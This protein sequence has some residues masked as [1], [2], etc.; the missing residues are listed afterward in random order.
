MPMKSTFVSK[1]GVSRISKK[2]DNNFIDASRTSFGGGL[3]LSSDFLALWKNGWS[4]R[5]R[6]NE[7]SHIA[8]VKL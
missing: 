8:A 1:W 2:T 5:K 3:R 7:V 6:G 4:N